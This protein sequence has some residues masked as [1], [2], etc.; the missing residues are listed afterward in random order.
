MRALYEWAGD[1]LSPAVEQAMLAWLEQNPRN[2][3]GTRPYSLDTYGLTTNQL[4]P[5][6][7]HY[8]SAF[9]IELEGA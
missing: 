5:T 6:F 7:A 4:E 2:R 8:V 9:G 3:F 1:E